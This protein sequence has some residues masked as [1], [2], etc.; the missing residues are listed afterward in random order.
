MTLALEMQGIHKRFGSVQALRGA[1]FTLRR[2]EVHALLGENGAGK[3]TLMHVAAGLVEPEQGTIRVDGEPVEI[4]TPRAARRLGIGMVHQHFTSVPAFTVAENVALAAGWPIHPRQLRRRMAELIS[5][6]GIELDPEV[7]ASGLSVAALER[8]EILKALATEATVLL[9][10]EPTG[11]LSPVE[12]E[13]LLLLVRQLAKG[14]AAIVLITHKLREALSHAHRITVLRRG[15]VTFSGPADGVAENELARSMLG[16]DLPSGGPRLP[17]QVG[18]IMV[19][20]EGVSVAPIDGRGPGL[21]NASFQLKAGEMVGVA[22]VEGNGQRELL[23]AVA[24]LVPHKGQLMVTGPVVL[25]PEDRTQEGLIPEFSLADNLTLGLADRAPWVHRGL[26]HRGQ[27]IEG[28]EGII[29]RYGIHA[30]SPE[31]AAATLSG[32]N[33][34]KLILARA[35]EAAPRTLVAENPGRGLDARAIQYAWKGLRAA[36]DQG[37][38]VLIHAADVDELLEWCD[39][40]MVVADGTVREL[41]AGGDRNVLGALMLARRSP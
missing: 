13:E 18:P 31:A 11:S 36:A 6:V 25:V 34:Q 27:A 16:D 12:S 21:T 29:R 9:L 1:D 7:T 38:S 35:L 10:D 2:G 17:S 3:T 37:A 40:L 23:R 24:G 41:P 15:L 28:T 30:P 19:R 39:R 22:A 32:G 20:A 8:L 14:G 5:R 33:Q 26:I 4:A